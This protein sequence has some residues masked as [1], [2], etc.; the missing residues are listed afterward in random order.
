MGQKPVC[1][2]LIAPAQLRKQ[3]EE[4]HVRIEYPRATRHYRANFT[5]SCSPYVVWTDSERI[6]HKYEPLRLRCW[7]VVHAEC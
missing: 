3:T 7:C 4:H 1:S 5:K 2:R 6:A